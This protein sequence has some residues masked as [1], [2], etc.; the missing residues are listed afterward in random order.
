MI[1]FARRQ[2]GREEVAFKFFVSRADY[3]AEVD[4]Y[5]NDALGDFLPMAEAYVD[6]ADRA[7]CDAYGNPLPPC[8][9][10][11]RGDTLHDRLRIA[12]TDKAGTAQVRPVQLRVWWSCTA[13]A[14]GT[15]CQFGGHAPG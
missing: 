1:Q 3:A 5:R 2:R 13:N 9:V 6:N 12:L 8:I 11:E 7:L 4:L 15:A 14:C 10:M